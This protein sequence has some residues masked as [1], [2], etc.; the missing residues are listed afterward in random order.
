MQKNSQDFDLQ[1]ALR[2]AKTPAGQQLLGM[3]RDADSGTLK[4]AAD[5]ANAGNTAD[6]MKTLNSILS[7]P[8]A[9]KLLEALR[10]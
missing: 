1:E 5:Q 7:S 10:R 6:A 2:L 9:K 4:Q 8:E 3:L